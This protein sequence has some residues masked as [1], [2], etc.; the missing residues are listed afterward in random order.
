MQQTSDAIFNCSTFVSLMIP[1]NCINMITFTFENIISMVDHAKKQNQEQ[2]KD[3][4]KPKQ[5]KPIQSINQ[6]INQAKKSSKKLK[7]KN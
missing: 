2:T 1:S 7:Q 6:I 4:T 3:N 5:A